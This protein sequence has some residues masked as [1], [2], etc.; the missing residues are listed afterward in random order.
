MKEESL[1]ARGLPDI[2]MSKSAPPVAG[3]LPQVYF[4]GV[5]TGGQIKSKIAKIYLSI[6]PADPS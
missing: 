4:V 1:M 2:F 5:K 6:T 3:H